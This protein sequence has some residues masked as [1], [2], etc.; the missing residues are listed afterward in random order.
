MLIEA[1]IH[2]RVAWS[3]YSARFLSFW[4]SVL[5]FR[6]EHQGEPDPA[7]PQP[8]FPCGGVGE[9]DQQEGWQQVGKQRTNTT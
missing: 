8:A 7:V 9:G 5:L 6:A 3:T 2:Q 1:A 4:F